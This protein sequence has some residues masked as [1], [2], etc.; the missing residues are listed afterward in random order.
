[1]R[2]VRM[3]GVS[4]WSALRL[5]AGLRSNIWDSVVVGVVFSSKIRVRGA[6]SSRVSELSVATVCVV[7]ASYVSVVN[8]SSDP[9]GFDDFCEAPAVLSLCACR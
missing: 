8:V 2:R 4:N 7:V 3:F 9:E 5:A 1:M 6:G